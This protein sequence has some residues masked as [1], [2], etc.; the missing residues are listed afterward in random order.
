MDGECGKRN[1]LTAMFTLALYRI[2][3]RF[4]KRMSQV[5]SLFYR[6]VLAK[7]SIRIDISPKISIF[8][9]EMSIFSPSADAPFLLPLTGCTRL[10][11]GN[12]P[13]RDPMSTLI[14]F[15]ICGLP[16]TL[17]A[18]PPC[19]RPILFM[20]LVLKAAEVKIGGSGAG[21]LTQQRRPKTKKI[22]WRRR[23][24]LL[25]G[26]ILVQKK[27][28]FAITNVDT[29]WG[30]HK[31]ETFLKIVTSIIG[32][33]SGACTLLS[34]FQHTKTKVMWEFDVHVLKPYTE[35]VSLKSS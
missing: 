28:I 34:H 23:D 10:R 2:L 31:Q 17:L 4:L 35:Y 29:S 13:I 8:Y 6:L 16:Q 22:W 21:K 15:K 7:I 3:S 9:L 14:T 24:F 20:V 25:R 5:L 12:A 18:L 19:H 1:R 27:S 26:K 32:A 30:V 11:K 33:C